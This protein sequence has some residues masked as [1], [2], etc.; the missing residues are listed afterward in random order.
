L[1]GLFRITRRVCAVIAGGREVVG[2][3]QRQRAR[4]GPGIAHQRL[5]DREAGI[6]VD[7]LRARL[8]E[9]RDREEHRDLAARHH[10]D[11]LRIDGRAG[12]P[13]DVVRDGRAQLG[14]ALGRRV[15]VVAVAQRPAGGLD[16]V[17]GG[18]EVRLADAQVDHRPA[19]LGQGVGARQN[20][21]GA[22]GAETVQGGGADDHAGR[23]VRSRKRGGRPAR[24]TSR[25]RRTGVVR[26]ASPARKPLASL[27]IQPLDAPR[28]GG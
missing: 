27:H 17:L 6:G 1:P 12:A 24:R 2:L 18:A 21:E 20:L 8:A 11:V 22:F 16:D 13:A 14:D 28:P 4:R 15:A 10:D 26:H 19:L 25:G 9:H 7:D 5:V 23:G 3:A